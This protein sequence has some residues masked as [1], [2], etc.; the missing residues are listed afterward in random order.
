MKD[1]LRYQDL[2]VNCIW[3]NSDHAAD[4]SYKMGTLILQKL[5]LRFH[6][7]PVIMSAL[8]AEDS[9]LEPQRNQQC[10][11]VAIAQLLG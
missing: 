6:C 4:A 5:V 1:Y 7:M 8:H 9:K 11:G 2:T 10:F 3:G